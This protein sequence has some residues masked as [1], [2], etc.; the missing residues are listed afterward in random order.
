MKFYYQKSNNRIGIFFP[1]DGD[2]YFVYLLGNLWAD[3]L[4]ISNPNYIVQEFLEYDIS[5]E[6]FLSIVGCYVAG[7]IGIHRNGQ[8][9]FYEIKIENLR[10]LHPDYPIKSIEYFVKMTN[11][12]S[13]F[14]NTCLLRWGNKVYSEDI[15]NYETLLS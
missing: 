12:F 6:E 10:I 1:Y 4:R 13:D 11:R 9:A 15:L 8:R 7:S 5:P 3:L 2:R 14:S